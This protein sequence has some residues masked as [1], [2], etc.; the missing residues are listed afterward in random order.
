MYIPLPT[1]PVRRYIESIASSAIR[2]VYVYIY[3]Y[4]K[5]RKLAYMYRRYIKVPVRIYINTHTYWPSRHISVNASAWRI[6]HNFYIYY[7][8]VYRSEFGRKFHGGQLVCVILW[9]FMHHYHTDMI[10]GEWRLTSVHFYSKHLAVLKDV[11]YTATCLNI[12]DILYILSMN[13][14]NS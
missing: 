5:V 9:W 2:C 11:I 10:I 3:I 8:Y 4:Q 14:R 7:K 1:K 12:Y 6:F 13:I